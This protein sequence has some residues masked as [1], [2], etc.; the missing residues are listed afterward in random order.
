MNDRE[1]YLALM[2][3]Q[4]FDRFPLWPGGAWDETLIRWH[5]EGLPQN[6]TVDEYFKADKKKEIPV[7]FGMYPCFERQVI[8][9]DGN[10]RIVRAETGIIQKEKVV[11]SDFTMPQFLEY[12]IKNRADFEK[13][14]ERYNFQDEGRIGPEFGTIVND[15]SDRDYVLILNGGRDISFFGALREWCGI[16]NLSL[17]FYDDPELVHDMME[18]I[19]NFCI[20][21]LSKILS[22]VV[23]DVVWAW[24]DMAY[25]NA[26]LISPDMFSE[27]MLPCYQKLTETIKSFGVN[28]VFVDSD[29]NIEGLIDLW[30]KG[31][32]DGVFPIERQCGM[33]PIKLRKEYGSQLLMYGGINKNILALDRQHIYEEVMPKLEFFAANGSGYIPMADH[34]IPPNVPFENY[35]YMIELIK[36]FR[37]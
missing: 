21:L 35:A 5:K 30:L 15:G 9:Q 28:H 29:G 25:K 7:S 20:S 2:N 3:F 12:P 31:G 18:F 17:L 19:L 6:Q 14:K 36:G 32:V 1:R 27:F 10:T 34:G 8:S 22:L 4:Y 16:E 13:I 37:V 26:S 11:F 23:P 33:D 24:E